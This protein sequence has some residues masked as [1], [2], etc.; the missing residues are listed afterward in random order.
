MR[1]YAHIRSSQVRFY[2]CGTY[3][4][5]FAQHD[6]E[7]T[8]LQTILFTLGLLADQSGTRCADSEPSRRPVRMISDETGSSLCAD[9]RVLFGG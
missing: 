6:R 4:V 1:R 9:P 2:A 5:S 3:A 7:V 8:S